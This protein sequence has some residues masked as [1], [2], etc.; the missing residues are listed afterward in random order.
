MPKIAYFD[1]S[2]TTAVAKEV[3]DEMIPFFSEKYGNPSSIHAMGDAAAAA[4]SGA[5]KKVAAALGCMPSEIIF[6]SGGTE[7]DNLALMGFSSEKKKVITS[8]VE[9]SAILETCERM[10]PSGYDV[11]ILPVDRDGRV[12]ASDLMKVIDKNTA[13]VSVMTANNVIGT[14]QP[15]AELAK[16]AH[17]HGALFHTDAVQ[18]FTKTDIDIANIDMLSISGHKIHGPKGI[19]ALYVRNGVDLRATMLGGGQ[20]YGR[21][22]STENVPGIVGLGK[23]A[24]LAVSTM[25]QDIARMTRLRDTMI[26]GILTIKGSYLNGPTDGRLCNN[27]HFGFGG[28]KGNDLVL[29]LSKMNIMASAAS[30]C[31]AGSTEPS[32]VMT[33][34]GRS[35]KEA[36]SSLRISSSRYTTDDEAEHL[37][38]S[39]PKALASLR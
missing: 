33:A 28:I 8:A 2:G 34:I 15:V 14:I 39:L 9:H 18:A 37:L 35:P 24:E 30:A 27:A 22:S 17:E 20:E 25:R 23:A 4:V 10:R 29:A 26:D 32:H 11:R 3:L 1:N 13:L 7:A 6:T 31:S 21:R 5:R 38:T 36:L 19:G 16:I 12:S